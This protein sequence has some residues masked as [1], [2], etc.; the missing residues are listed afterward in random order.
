MA[1]GAATLLLARQL[2]SL[3]LQLLDGVRG[4]VDL[5]TLGFNLLTTLDTSTVTW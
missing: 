4:R 3:L 1:P 2:L 5:A